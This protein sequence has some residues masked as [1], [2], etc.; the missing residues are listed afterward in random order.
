MNDP[1]NLDHTLLGELI[2]RCWQED[3]PYYT[4]NRSVGGGW[5]EPSWM[6]RAAHSGLELH[7]S[8]RAAAARRKA[9]RS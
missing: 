7:W 1:L 5:L 2:A 3:P 6:R 9:D 8:R 4:L